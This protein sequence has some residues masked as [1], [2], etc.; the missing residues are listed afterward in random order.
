LPIE[1]TRIDK[2]RTRFALDSNSRLTKAAQA[3]GATNT[4]WTYTYNDAQQL[5]ASTKNGVTTRYEYAD[6]LTESNRLQAVEAYRW[7]RKSARR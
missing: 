6:V 1:E 4:T 3:G 5:T 7:P 2:L